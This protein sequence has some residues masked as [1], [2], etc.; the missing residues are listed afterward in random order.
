MILDAVSK[1]GLTALPSQTNF[2]YVEVPDADAVQQ[3]MASRN[4]SIRGAYGPWKQYSR[5]S[6]G[7]I[8]DV[9]RYAAALPEI[10]A[11]LAG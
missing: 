11:D 9:A 5:V 4:I 2:V 1:A 7:K 10:M 3:A 6:T 8:E